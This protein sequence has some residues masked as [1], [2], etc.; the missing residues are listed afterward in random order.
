MTKE[1][2][3]S[4][5]TWLGLPPLLIEAR[6]HCLPNM[7]VATL[8]V[9]IVAPARFPVKT[10]W[11]FVGEVIDWYAFCKRQSCQAIIIVATLMRFQDEESTAA[12]MGETMTGLNFVLRSLP[13]FIPFPKTYRVEIHTR[14]YMTWLKKRGGPFLGTQLL[15]GKQGFQL[16]WLYII[17][18]SHFFQA[19][20]E[21]CLRV[22]AK[23]GWGDEWLGSKLWTRRVCAKKR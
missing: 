6:I 19:Q 20:S 17:L 10:W 11:R 16:V 7:P 1:K 23:S 21:P 12:I 14:S 18:S 13:S 9:D 3:L 4:C 15:Q 5:Q 8:I 22:V 2:F